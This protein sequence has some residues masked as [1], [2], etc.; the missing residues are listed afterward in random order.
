MWT[1]TEEHLRLRHPD[2]KAE[3]EPQSL[4]AGV[5]LL[6]PIWSWFK[7]GF[8]SYQAENAFAKGTG[9]SSCLPVG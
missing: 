4:Y 3:V 8:V 7:P 6:S 5:Y 1:P 9:A 2:M